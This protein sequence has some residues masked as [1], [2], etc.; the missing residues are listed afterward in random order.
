MFGLVRVR[1]RCSVWLGLGLELVSDD[2]IN[3]L[4]IN[5]LRINML[6]INMLI[7]VTLVC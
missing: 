5:M 6:R 3:M 1:V 7:S 2:S 4:R